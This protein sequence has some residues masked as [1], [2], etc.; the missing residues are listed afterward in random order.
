MYSLNPLSWF[1]PRPTPA[2]SEPTLAREFTHNPNVPW[3]EVD[4]SNLVRVAYYPRDKVLLVMFNEDRG[5]LYRGVPSGVFNSLI[6]SPSKGVYHSAYIKWAYPY[7][8][9]MGQ[10]ELENQ[11]RG[12]R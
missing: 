8:G 9:P 7:S 6:S 10:T 12:M 5:Y 2:S 3:I 1:R 11:A 4:S